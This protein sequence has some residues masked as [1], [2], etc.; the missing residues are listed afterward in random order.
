MSK[1]QRLNERMNYCFN[2]YDLTEDYKF[3]SEGDTIEHL[4][5]LESEDNFYQFASTFAKEKNINKV[6]DIGCAYCHQSEFFL[7]IKIY[8]LGNFRI[9]YYFIF[10]KILINYIEFMFRYI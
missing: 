6:Y 3:I 7:I 2:Q 1:Y 8:S 4:L 10:F 9:I 5:L